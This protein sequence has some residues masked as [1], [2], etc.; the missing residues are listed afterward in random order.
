MRIHEPTKN[1]ITPLSVFD[2]LLAQLNKMG[3]KLPSAQ[4]AEAINKLNATRK[5]VA[6]IKV[7]K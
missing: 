2:D 1:D 3:R 5:R 7:E 6:R 4:L